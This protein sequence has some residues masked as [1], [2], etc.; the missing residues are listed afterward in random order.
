MQVM[1]L[2]ANLASCVHGVPWIGPLCLATC[3]GCGHM[4]GRHALPL[5]HD[6][7]GKHVVLKGHDRACA[8]DAG[9]PCK[10]FREAG[11]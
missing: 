2:A 3:A 10:N 9:C 7:T 8:A 5:L 11:R 6:E 4:C 1:R